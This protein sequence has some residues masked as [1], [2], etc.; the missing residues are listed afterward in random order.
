VAQ[1]SRF[2][3]L[4]QILDIQGSFSQ[5]ATRVLTDEPAGFGAPITGQAGTGAAISTF[6]AGVSTLTGLT[7]MTANSVGNFLTVSGAASPG[8]NGTFLI[9]SFVDATS[10]TVSNAAGVAPDSGIAWTERRAYCLNDDLD[11]ER[12]DRQAIKGVA[13]SAPIPTYQRPTAVGTLVPANL[14]NIAGKTT[15][16]RGFIFNRLFANAPVTAASTFITLTSVGNLKHADAVDKTGVPCFDAA[17]Y[18]GDYLACYARIQNPAD[19]TEFLVLAGPNQGEK[20][21]ALAQNGA[22]PSTSPDSV[23]MALFSVPIGGELSVDS[24]PYVWEAGLPTEVNIV[25]G[26]FERLDLASEYTLRTLETLGV[27]ESG[28]LRQDIT[29][30]QEVIGVADGDTFLTLTNKTNFFP[31]VLLDPTPSVTEALNTLNAQIGNR[32]YTGSILTDGQTITA[33]LQ[34]LANSVSSANVV[35]HIERLTADLPANTSH[36]LPGGAVYTPDGTNNGLGLAVY[37]RGILRDP[38]T[39]LNGDDYNE[40]DST[41][42]TFYAKQKAGDHINY[43]V[44]G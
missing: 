21:Y 43:Y 4:D 2:N 32:D 17:P 38:G 12:T 29:D 16:A 39:V 8:N 36:T 37:T 11:F 10:V 35:R 44:F 23:Q 15:D 27:E 25:Y 28:S 19:G 24:T 7:G 14:A 42:I 26:Y 31:F 3:A 18:A 33:S 6:N 13:Y 40:T 1:F 20:I 22:G 34:A 9:V 5:T 41:H 30:L